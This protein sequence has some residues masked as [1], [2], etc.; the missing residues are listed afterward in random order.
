MESKELRREEA[1]ERNKE[2]SSLFCSI[3]GNRKKKN[4]KPPRLSQNLSTSTALPPSKKKKSTH[5]V[6]AGNG[7]SAWGS[8]GGGGTAARTAA[9]RDGDG[10]GGGG[11]GGN[12]WGGSSPGSGVPP[13]IGVADA[14]VS[15]FFLFFFV[16]SFFRPPPP[17]PPPTPP[18]PCPPF[19]VPLSRAQRDKERESET[20]REGGEEL[21]FDLFLMLDNDPEKKKPIKKKLQRALSSARA[22]LDARE[23]ELASR[24][25]ALARAEEEVRRQRA[26]NAA[27][28]SSGAAV[29]GRPEKNW[30]PCCSVLH[31]DIQGEIPADAQAAVTSAYRAYLGLVFCLVYNCAAT[32]ARLA[33]NKASLFPFFSFRARERGEKKNDER[34]K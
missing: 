15:F 6:I 7:A 25:A 14:D 17:P 8:G 19:C 23:R 4:I 9:A 22:A 28:A 2:K 24:E 32:F 1:R 30:P 34:K 3:G 27:G 12:A 31:H 5:S 29:D 13:V 20:E 21:Q 26:S 33:A 11:G 10:G 18:L 16:P